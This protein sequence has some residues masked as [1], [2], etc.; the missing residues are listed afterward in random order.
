[1]AGER[2]RERERGE[3]GGAV[4]C[5]RAEPRLDVVDTSSPSLNSTTLLRHTAAAWAPRR[6]MQEFDSASIS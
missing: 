6:R 1:M 5:R 2:E 4:S 3:E